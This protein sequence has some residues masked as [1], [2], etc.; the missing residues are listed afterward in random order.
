MNKNAKYDKTSKKLKI[1]SKI[2]GKLR[3][4]RK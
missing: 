2:V 4:L 3:N 1:K